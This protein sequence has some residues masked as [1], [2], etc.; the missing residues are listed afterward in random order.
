[1]RI[2]RSL[3]RKVRSIL[4][5]TGC[6]P[7]SSGV[8]VSWVPSEEYIEG[9]IDRRISEATALMWT[10]QSVCCGKEQL[11]QKPKLSI[12]QSI[13]VSVR[14]DGNNKITQTS[15]QNECPS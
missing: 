14:S 10:F 9:Q 11:N 2:N 3:A 5:G 7:P 6:Q 4:S 12:Y 8:Y 15:G 13:H 1:M